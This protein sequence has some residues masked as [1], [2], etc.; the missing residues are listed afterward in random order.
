MKYIQ[1][2]E[3]SREEYSGR[4]G[5]KASIFRWKGNQGKYIQMGGE[6]MEVYLGGTEIQG[7]R[8]R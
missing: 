5:I 7:I 8:L 2:G 4:R 6:S 3:E 1:V